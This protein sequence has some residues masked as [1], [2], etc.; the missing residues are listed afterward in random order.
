MARRRVLRKGGRNTWATLRQRASLTAKGSGGSTDLATPAAAKARRKSGGSARTA[1]VVRC[2]NCLPSGS[3]H[4]ETLVAQIAAAALPPPKRQQCLV[5]GRKFKSDLSWDEPHW[6]S[7]EVNGG[8]WLP[9]GGHTTGRGAERDYEKCALTALA[10]YRTVF[11]SPGQ[12]KSGKALAWIEALL[13][14]S[15]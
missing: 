1:S 11:V 7:V 8:L 12:V 3:V 13:R 6:L 2:G 9:K 5:P 15:V 14:R 4:E 10:G